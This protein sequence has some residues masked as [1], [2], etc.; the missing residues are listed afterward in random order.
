M[1]SCLTS[2][3]YIV[4]SHWMNPVTNF[5][6][7][8]WFCQTILWRKWQKWAL[9]KQEGSNHKVGHELCCIMCAAPVNLQDLPCC[10]EGYLADSR[11]N[12]GS[13]QLDL[14]LEGLPFGKGVRSRY[15]GKWC[16]MPTSQV[17]PSTIKKKDHHGWDWKKIIHKGAVQSF[18]DSCSHQKVTIHSKSEMMAL[19]M[20][21]PVQAWWN[22]T[23]PHQFERGCISEGIDGWLIGINF[24]LQAT[25]SC[26]YWSQVN[27]KCTSIFWKGIRLEC[28]EMTS[29]FSSQ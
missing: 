13:S 12:A 2:N 27:R 5:S 3:V 29:T 7:G 19:L 21:F 4:K 15:Y 26:S 14:I 22:P 1:S 18:K 10:Q 24:K 23:S 17:L 11:R 25:H 28:K 6:I 8:G 16:T 20:W 9:S